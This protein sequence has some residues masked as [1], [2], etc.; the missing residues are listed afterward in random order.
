M[1]NLWLQPAGASISDRVVEARVKF[2]CACVFNDHDD[3]VL[4]VEQDGQEEST[5][6]Q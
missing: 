4:P 3:C 1:L 5:E 2:F 6:E